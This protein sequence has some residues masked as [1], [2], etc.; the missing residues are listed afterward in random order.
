YLA[1]WMP[2]EPFEQR[3]SDTSVTGE[4]AFALTEIDHRRVGVE[5]HPAHLG[6]QQ[7]LDQQ[8][9][10]DL[11]THRCRATGVPDD[12]S[13]RRVSIELGSRTNSPSTVLIC[14]RVSDSRSKV[15]PPARL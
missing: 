5:H 14:D 8:L 1:P 11:L 15:S 4:Q 12:V 10:R 9:R 6:G 13:Q 7:G 3:R 2:T